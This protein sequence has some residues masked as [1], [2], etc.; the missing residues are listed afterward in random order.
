[1]L[2]SLM[3][4]SEK[5]S[6]ESL[7]LDRLKLNTKDYLL[8]TLHRPYNVDDQNNLKNIIDTLSKVSWKIVFP[9]H[10]RTHKMLL[11]FGVKPGKNIKLIEPVGYIDFIKLQ[12]NAYKIITDSGGIQKEAYLLKIPCITLRPET[13]WIETVKA[14]WNILV[15]F[16]RDAILTAIEKFEPSGFQ[17]NV[18]GEYSCAEKM[19]NILKDYFKNN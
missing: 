14:G 15:G 6:R 10:P 1:M 12:S 7:I 9:V 18:F 13:E 16:E 2:D 4:Y 11:Q 17:D 3:I 5:A 8:L 19:V